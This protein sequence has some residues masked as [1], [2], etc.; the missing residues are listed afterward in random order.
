M[1]GPPNV[2]LCKNPGCPSGLPIS[3]K[4]HEAAGGALC[5]RVAEQG[6]CSGLE[7]RFWKVGLC[8]WV[9]VSGTRAFRLS[10][11]K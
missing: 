4:S 7:F 9:E 5:H 1:G 8:F 6:A 2:Y 11:H 10:L 3:R